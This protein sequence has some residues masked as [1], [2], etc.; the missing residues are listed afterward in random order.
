MGFVFALVLLVIAGALA[1]GFVVHLI[2]SIPLW[3][4]LGGALLVL[5]LRK[6]AHGRRMLGRGTAD[7]YLGRW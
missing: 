1:L 7:R 6:S 5:Y 3:L 4:L 2:F